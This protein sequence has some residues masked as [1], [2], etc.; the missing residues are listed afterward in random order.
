MGFQPSGELSSTDGW[1]AQMTVPDSW[2]SNMEVSS[3]ICYRKYVMLIFHTLHVVFRVFAVCKSAVSVW[4]FSSL[5]W[6]SV[7]DISEVTL[8]RVG[9]V[10]G[11]L[12]V[13]MKRP[14]QSHGI[15]CFITIS[16]LQ[17]NINKKNCLYVTVLCMIIMVHKDMSSSY[18]SVDCIRL[19][20]CLVLLSVFQAPLCLQSSWCY[21]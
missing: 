8:R 4:K 9:L 12:Q 18:R 3:F 16:S 13:V 19:C 1:W 17:G 11:W 2:S 7:G 10:P 5:A 14:H 15:Y 6:Y 21:I 20:S